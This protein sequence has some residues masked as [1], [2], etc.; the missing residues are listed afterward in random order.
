MGLGAGDL[1]DR[2]PLGGQ[3]VDG[4]GD[5]PGVSGREVPSPERRPGR[6][7]LGVGQ[8]LGQRGAGRGLGRGDRGVPAEP[9]PRALGP[10]LT[11][12][13]PPDR[14]GQDRDLH[15]LHPRLGPGQQP[16][17][18]TELDI[19]QLP[20]RHR[21]HPIQGSRQRV[22]RIIGHAD[23]VQPRP[24]PVLELHESNL[25][26]TTDKTTPDPGPVGKILKL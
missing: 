25:E 16:D 6:C 13:P 22:E 5:H 4:A 17:R 3:G 7:Q 10:P 11:G 8:V 21:R 26:V 20:Q 1:V 14:L 2:L 18:R 9:H 19:G 15:R 24:A 12:H 23:P